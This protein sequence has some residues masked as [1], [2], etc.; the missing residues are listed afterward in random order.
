LVALRAL[1][2]LQKV[3]ADA[4][5]WVQELAAWE[6]AVALEV[7]EAHRPHVEE[8]AVLVAAGTYGH[9]RKQKGAYDHMDTEK[10]CEW[11]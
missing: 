9:R 6:L 1:F 4:V 5:L 11:M 3:E 7:A 10:I 8:L 2:V